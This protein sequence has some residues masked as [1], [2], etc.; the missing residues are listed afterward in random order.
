LI[1]Y[2]GRSGDAGRRIEKLDRLI[3]G[4]VHFRTADNIDAT[5]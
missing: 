3:S 1:A 2:P 5:W 4:E